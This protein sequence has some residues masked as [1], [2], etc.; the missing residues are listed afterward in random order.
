MI[1]THPFVRLEVSKQAFEEIRDR[2][3]VAEY[4]DALYLDAGQVVLIDM[5]GIALVPE[6]N[7]TTE[8]KGASD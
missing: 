4:S 1:P 6:K 2:L 7:E 3:R 5:H 8:E